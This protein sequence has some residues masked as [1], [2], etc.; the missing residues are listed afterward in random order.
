MSEILR[1][2]VCMK[3]KVSIK[4]REQE[5][6]GIISF[7]LSVLVEAFLMILGVAVICGVLWVTCRM[8]LTAIMVAAVV[9][10]F[11][12]IYSLYTRQNST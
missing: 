11:F 7:I 9:G 6:E 4:K 1:K 10:I 5:K 2:L 12:E 8:I 3:V